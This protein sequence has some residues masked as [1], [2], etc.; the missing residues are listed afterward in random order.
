MWCERRR[1]FFLTKSEGFDHFTRSKGPVTRLARA[2]PTGPSAEIIRILRV[3][4]LF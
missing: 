3:R 1:R 2:D 4:V